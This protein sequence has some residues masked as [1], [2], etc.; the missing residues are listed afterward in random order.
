MKSS[1]GD[2]TSLSAYEAGEQANFVS[3]D[4]IREA[5]CYAMAD[6]TAV[7][8][9]GS[10]TDATRYLRVYT[11]TTERHDGKWNTSKYRLEVTAGTAAIGITDT[12][13]RI[14]GIQ[15]QVTSTSGDRHAIAMSGTAV[16]N[17]H[18]SACLLR[19]VYSS[20]GK[21]N[22]VQQNAGNATGY[23]WNNIAY[24]FINAAEQC[25]GIRQVGHLYAY[26]NTMQNCAAGLT[27][28]DS[29]KTCIVKNCL[30]QDCTN[31]F[32]GTFD[33]GTANN[34]SDIASD[35]P[36]SNP[37]TGEV[38]FVDEAGDDFHLSASDAF[39]KDLGV[40]LSADA[41]LAFSDDIDGGTRVAPWSIGADQIIAAA[42]GGAIVVNMQLG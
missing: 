4:E 14:E 12:F 3:L 9:S 40:D 36:G 5:E 38:T 26:N 23:V 15:V 29:S 1:G 34:C 32:S 42:A 16:F 30:A 6:T 25:N 17:G 22:G 13:A 41:N 19:A 18:V 27:E 21:G 24:D 10:T 7:T 37:S 39:A 31:G 28:D 2:Y 20:T 35:A 8:I 11:P 33:A